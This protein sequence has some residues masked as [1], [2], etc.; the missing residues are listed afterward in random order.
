MTVRECTCSIVQYLWRR[1]R[2]SKAWAEWWWRQQPSS[3]SSS[4]YWAE[5]KNSRFPL[6]RLFPATVRSTP[7]YVCVCVCACQRTCMS[8]CVCMVSQGSDPRGPIYFH[9]QR[10]KWAK[11]MSHLDSRVWFLFYFILHVTVISSSR[12]PK[13]KRIPTPPITLLGEH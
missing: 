5:K 6:S 1:R 11:P 3:L 7:L 2:S 8:V 13:Y 4:S 12:S 9:C 10:T